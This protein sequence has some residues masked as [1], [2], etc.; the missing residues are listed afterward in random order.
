MIVVKLIN[1][2]FKVEPYKSIF[3]FVFVVKSRFG[4]GN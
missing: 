2:D 4:E 3:N 1:P